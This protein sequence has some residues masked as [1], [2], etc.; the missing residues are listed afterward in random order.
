MPS[1]YDYRFSSARREIILDLLKKLW[2]ILKNSNCPIFTINS[3]DLKEWTTTENDM[4]KKHR[5]DPLVKN[6]A[7][8]N[9]DEDLVKPET[10]L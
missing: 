10:G 8:R 5:R 1:S 9:Y 2:Y 3:K 6:P 4:K 7:W